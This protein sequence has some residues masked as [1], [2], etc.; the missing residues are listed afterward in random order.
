MCADRREVHAYLRTEEAHWRGAF[1]RSAS[2]LAQGGIA[3]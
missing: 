1:G 3:R 2:W